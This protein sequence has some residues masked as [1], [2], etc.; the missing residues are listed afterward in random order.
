MPIFFVASILQMSVYTA[1]KLYS[2][3]FTGSNPA[4]HPCSCCRIPSY[5]CLVLAYWSFAGWWPIFGR[6]E[7]LAAPYDVFW[8]QIKPLSD[9][10]L[11]SPCR[12]LF[13][14]LGLR[15]LL[16]DLSWETRRIN[17][18]ISIFPC[19]S[20]CLFRIGYL[21]TMLQIGC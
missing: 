4:P 21:L 7:H 3:V 1:Q 8:Q 20:L 5:R 18:E 14:F 6:I 11:R 13:S 10:V 15:L 16:Y 12:P 9:G 19:L 17:Q 2:K